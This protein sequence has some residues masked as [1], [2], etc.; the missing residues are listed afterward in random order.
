MKTKLL[1]LFIIFS[2]LLLHAEDTVKVPIDENQSIEELLNTNRVAFDFIADGMATKGYLICDKGMFECGSY[3]SW[4]TYIFQR[5]EY[6]DSELCNVYFMAAGEIFDTPD[7]NF[8]KL[9]T[10]DSGYSGYTHWGGAHG[11]RTAITKAV[12][13][14]S[15]RN[16][17][18]VYIYYN[19]DERY[20]AQ[21][22]AIVIDNLRIRSKPSINSEI[23]GNL[24]KLS[25]I[26]LYEES[27]HKDT[28]DNI[29]SPWYKTQTVDGKEGW[30]FGG[31]VRIFFNTDW[32]LRQKKA[33][34][35][36]FG[37]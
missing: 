31:Y 30:V 27:A 25:E 4:Q 21:C 3:G 35:R 29:E 6:V 18:P 37:G 1:V 17:Y 14:K 24:A 12:V 34:L 15:I 19:S 7:Y 26:T 23:V 10:G 33:I 32:R 11:H 2:G 36:K 20:P 16:E 8:D 9:E 28:I 22:Q 13:L 5:V